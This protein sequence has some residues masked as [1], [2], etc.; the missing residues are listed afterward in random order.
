VS[1]A[2]R[3]SP[4]ARVSMSAGPRRVGTGQ[5]G[6]ARAK[7]GRHGPRRVGTCREG[8]RSAWLT[9]PSDSTPVHPLFPRRSLRIAV[10]HRPSSPSLPGLAAAFESGEL[11]FDQLRPLA[12]MATP[13]NDA[14]LASEA[15][16][17]TTAADS[18]VAVEPLA[19]CPPSA[20]LVRGGPT[21]PVNLVLLRVS[22]TGPSAGPLESVSRDPPVGRRRH[23][24]RG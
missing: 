15:P 5:E 8:A 9:A 19:P 17:R 12:M 6:S 4:A 11:S 23:L 1:G 2:G 7:R 22:N 16:T 18:P 3:V 20:A 13:D 10:S 24:E 21:D 14:A